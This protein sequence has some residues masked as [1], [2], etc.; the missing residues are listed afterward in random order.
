MYDRVKEIV[1]VFNPDF[2]LLHMIKL[3]CSPTF[4]AT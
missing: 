4:T 1:Q 3:K 2:Q